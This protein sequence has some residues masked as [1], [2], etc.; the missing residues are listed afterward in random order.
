ML[1]VDGRARAAARRAVPLRRLAV[2]LEDRPT[3]RPRT[4]RPNTLQ[5][6]VLGGVNFVLHAAGWLEGGLADRLREV[7]PR[8]RPVRDDGDASSK[9]VD[10]SRERPGARRDPRERPGHSTSSARAHTLANFETAFYRSTIADNNSFEQWQEDGSLDAAQRA[11]AI[12]K[13]M[14]AEYEAPPIDAGV[15]EALRD[16]IA[17]RKAS[18]PGLRGLGR[19]AL[20]PP[21]IADAARAAALAADPR[22]R[23]RSSSCRSRTRS[24]RPTFLPAGATVSVTASPAKGIEA[25]VALCEQLQARGF[26]AVPHLSARMIRDRAHLAE[27]IAWLEGAGVD[28]AFVVGGD[29][30]EPGDYP[31]G[32]SLLRAMAEIGHPLTEIGIPAYPQGHAF[33]ADAPLLEALRAK[34]AFA[35]YMT[36]QL[37]FDP[38]AIASWLAARRAEG[39]ALPV[40]LGLPGVAEPQRLLAISA[41]IGV[42]DTHRFLVKNTRFI[43]RLIRS[44]GFYRPGR[45]ARRARAAHRRSGE[46]DRRPAPVH[47]Q[48]GRRHRAL[49]DGLPRN[50]CGSGRRLTLETS[51]ARLLISAGV[52]HHGA[53]NRRDSYQE[54][55][56]DRPVE[57]TTT[58]RHR[59]GKVPSPG[60]SS[61]TIRE[62]PSRP[63]RAGRVLS[64]PGP[65]ARSDRV[66]SRGP[67]T[68]RSRPPARRG[69]ASGSRLAARPLAGRRRAGHAAVQPRRAAAGLPRGARRHPSRDRRRRPSGVPRGRRRADRDA[70]VRRQPAA[71]GGLGPRGPGRRGSTGGR[72]SSPARHARSAGATRS[73]AVRSG[74]SVR[75]RAAGRPSPRP[76]RGPRSASRSTACSRAG[77]T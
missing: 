60:R 69:S 63:F 15:D 68:A 36:T 55:R 30:K 77:S 16:F 44:G 11:N 6:T 48:R 35:S 49:A 12:W 18:M 20:P 42:A 17:R 40:H 3:R 1:Y 4:S 28:R 66:P 33:I 46:R 75:R 74:R 64:F 14:L 65:A 23:R 47:V 54:W 22:A 19:R 58:Y 61:C 39:I 21:L 76:P 50:G 5:P 8:R 9:G 31:D 62:L 38:N 25:T 53:H 56:R 32:L 34:A 13:K 67:M 71:S 45:P 52:G 73:S 2:R 43:A 27:L 7:H 24:T 70:V 29:A 37:C 57:A 51:R 72:P 41:R 59:V 26:R 10:L